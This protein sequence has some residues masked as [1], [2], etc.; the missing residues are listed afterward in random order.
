MSRY[1]GYTTVGRGDFFMMA[2]KWTTSWLICIQ[3]F[4][5]WTAS[6]ATAFLSGLLVPVVQCSRRAE[7]DL[8]SK[9]RLPFRKVE[10]VAKLQ[11]ELE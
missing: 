9:A 5:N 2:M 1:G 4:H 7:L 8:A 3:M 6:S 11:P 10:F